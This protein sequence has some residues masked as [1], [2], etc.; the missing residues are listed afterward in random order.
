M[1]DPRTG[2]TVMKE[3]L[4]IAGQTP[5]LDFPNLPNAVRSGASAFRRGGP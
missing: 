4:T 2:V 1:T 5:D 3:V